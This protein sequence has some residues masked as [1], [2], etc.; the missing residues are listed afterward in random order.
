MTKLKVLVT[1]LLLAF[2]A[3]TGAACAY[4]DVTAVDEDTVVVAENNG[5]LFGIFNAVYVCDVTDAG[6]A[7][8]S[9]QENP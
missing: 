7:N 2:L 9:S 6:L 8:C 1:G 5:F 3:S 4:A